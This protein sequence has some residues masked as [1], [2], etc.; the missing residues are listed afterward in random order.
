MSE[1][2]LQYKSDPQKAL[3]RMEAWWNREI[4]DRPT[5]QVYAPKLQEQRIPY[6]VKQHANLRDRWMDVEYQ[7]ECANANCANTYYAGEAMPTYMPNLGPELLTAAYGAPMQ[8][9]EST[10]WTEPILKDWA[11]LPGLTMDP[12]NE[13]VQAMLDMTKLALETGKEKYLVG[14]TDIH[15]GGDLAASLRDG[16]QFAMDL[17]TQPE[18]AQALMDHIKDAFFVFFALQARLFKEAGQTVQTSWLPL[19]TEGK[20][21]IPSN[22]FSC[23]ISNKMFEQYFL[24]EIIRETEF[25]DRSIYHLDGPGALRHLDTL[26]EIPSL[27]GIQWVYGAGNEPSTNWIDVLK[28]IQAKKKNIHMDIATADLDI[29]MENLRP[30]GVMFITWASSPEE[31]DAVVKK[32]AGWK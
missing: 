8:F 20:Y 4:L 16:E 30:E 2:V 28:R 31:A 15:P 7:V 19:C 17:A 26:L 21:Y 29:L 1:L 6:P 23:M 9:M 14:H 25:L 22:D 11:D 18:L 24:T 32:V 12:H 13:Y 5:I 10:S 3:E 27:G